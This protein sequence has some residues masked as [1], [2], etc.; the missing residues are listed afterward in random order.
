M[1]A[2]VESQTQLSLPAYIL[3]QIGNPDYLHVSLENGRIILS[4]AEP[5]NS[6]EVRDYLEEIGITGQDVE[7]A[8]KWARNR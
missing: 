5:K 6:D 2:K 3:N 8:I 7:D 4:P 1:L